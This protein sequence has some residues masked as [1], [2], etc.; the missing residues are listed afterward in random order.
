MNSILKIDSACWF[1]LAMG[2]VSAAWAVR[3]ITRKRISM[4]YRLG[5]VLA[6]IISIETLVFRN[7]VFFKVAACSSSLNFK[8]KYNKFLPLP[9]RNKRPAH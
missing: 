2:L 4:A 1:G 3:C 7:P 8:N 6:C 5:F 9:R